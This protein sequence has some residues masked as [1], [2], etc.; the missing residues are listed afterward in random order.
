MKRGQVCKLLMSSA[1][2]RS[3]VLH[4]VRGQLSAMVC[5]IRQEMLGGMAGR[6]AGGMAGLVAKCFQLEAMSHY[7]EEG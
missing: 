7:E 4:V 3:S 2:R 6:M 1:I 5:K